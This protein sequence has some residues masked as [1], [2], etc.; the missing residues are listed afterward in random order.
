VTNG[1][2]LDERDRLARLFGLIAVRA[3]EAIMQARASAGDPAT[4]S[5]GSPVTAAD[6]AADEIIRQCL[7][8]NVPDLPVI[9]EETCSATP[10]VEADRFVL[11]DPLD[12]TREFSAGHDEF[13]VHIG[14][15]RDGRAVLGVVG[16]PAL[17]EM[18]GGIVGGGAWKRTTAGESPIHARVPPASGL[19]V[20]ASRY[21]AHD[22]R[23][24]GFLA[25]RKIASVSNIG[26]G[27]KFCRVAEGVAD[28][29]PRFG[30]T[31]EWDSAGPQAV[32]E[33]AGGTVLDLA[34]Q[35]LAYGKPGWENPAFICAGLSG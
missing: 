20:V 24:D 8:R 12:G 13:T 30:R 33:A 21:H 3:G 10:V 7:L 17:G 26:S 4:K 34:G 29:Y 23:L 6:L 5:D 18:F 28:L 25:G 15:V 2:C 32:L 27:L 35:R 14:L 16:V 31:M 19:A 9:T 1:P 22:A 11:V